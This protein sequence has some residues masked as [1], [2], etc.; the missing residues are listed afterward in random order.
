MTVSTFELSDVAFLC[1]AT[2]NGFLM[3]GQSAL[4]IRETGI[5]PHCNRADIV[6]MSCNAGLNAL[7]V[8]APGRL[9]IRGK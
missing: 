8:T 5:S 1:C 3:P 9:L 6:G 7:G 4:L 2:S